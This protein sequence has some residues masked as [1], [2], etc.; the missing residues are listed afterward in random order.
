MQNYSILAFI[1]PIKNA[2]SVLPLSEKYRIEP[3]L[4]STHEIQVQRKES[5]DHQPTSSLPVNSITI[6]FGENGGGKT[7]LLLNICNTVVRRR[8]TRP[9]GILWEENDQLF[10]DPGSNLKNIKFDN[11]CQVMTRNAPYHEDAFGAAFYT[12]SPFEMARR[13]LALTESEAIDVTPS[14]GADNPFGGVPLLLAAQALPEDLDFIREMEVQPK[15]KTPS[16]ISQIDVYTSYRKPRSTPSEPKIKSVPEDI[17][18]ILRQL[19]SELNPYLSNTLAIELY[20]TRLDGKEAAATLLGHLSDSLHSST[21][22]RADIHTLHKNVADFLDSRNRVI[23]SYQ[24]FNSLESARN[25]SPN[26]LKRKSPFKHYV[27]DAREWSSDV[28]EGLKEAE[29]LGIL[30][31]SFLKLS[32]GQVAMLM[33]FASLSGALQ[34]LIQN[35]KKNVILTVDEG[36]MFMHPAWQRTYLSQLMNFLEHYR[37]HFNCIHLIV[38]THSLIVAGDAPPN[39]L[40]NVVSGKMQNGFAS[41]PDELLKKIYQV[42]D[43]AGK[44]AE[45]RYE[46]ISHYLKNGGPEHEA[47]EVQRLV[48]EIASDRLRTYLQDEVIRQMERQNAKD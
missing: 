18:K 31:W 16:L 37:G 48:D 17:R 46:K 23:S 39:R 1:I 14:F 12:T 47:L 36:E 15:V 21:D 25:G 10:F 29:S 27:Y 22:I 20:R 7:R 41:P 13:R 35:N 3:L 30:K 43:F 24:I 11:G 5:Y 40:F 44:M 42:P 6:T 33:L 8:G 4:G 32:S 9:L 28:V 45:Q 26:G 34:Q 38:S 2:I 19:P